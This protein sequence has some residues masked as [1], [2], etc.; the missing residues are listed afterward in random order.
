MGSWKPQSRYPDIGP[1]HVLQL[2]LSAARLHVAARHASRQLGPSAQHKAP[3][4]LPGP[5]GAPVPSSQDTA[6][7]WTRMLENPAVRNPN[8]ALGQLQWILEQGLLDSILPYISS[9]LDLQASPP[10]S[11]RRIVVASSSAS[12]TSE[13]LNQTNQSGPSLIPSGRLQIQ[14]PVSKDSE[15]DEGESK[16]PNDS[17]ATAQSDIQKILQS[18]I[19][20]HPGTPKKFRKGGPNVTLPKGSPDKVEGTANVTVAPSA[21]DDAPIASDAGHDSDVSASTSND[22]DQ[23]PTIVIHVCD[24]AHGLRQD[25][26]CSRD[27]LVRHIGYFADLT[28][29]QRLEDVDISVHCDVAVFEWL[30]RWVKAGQSP[31]HIKPTIEAKNAVSLLISADF[32][33]MLPLVSELLVYLHRHAQDVLLAQANL[34]CLPDQL[35]N[36]LSRQFS[37]WEVEAL[38]DPKDRLQGRLYSRLLQA[39]C[40]VNPEHT[41][42]IFRTAATLYRC[43]DCGALVTQQVDRLVECVPVNTHVTVA[44]AVFYAHTRDL[45]WS[46]T[47]HVKELKSSLKTWRLVYWRLWGQVHFMPCSTCGAVFPAAE[48]RRCRKHKMDPQFN[49][50]SDLSALSARGGDHYPC[51]GA[52]ALRFSP[53]PLRNGCQMCE[54]TVQLSRRPEEVWGALHSIYDDL[55]TYQVL[56][57]LPTAPSSARPQGVVWRGVPLVPVRTDRSF[58]DRSCF[59][60][61]QVPSGMSS[62]KGDTVMVFP[63]NATSVSPGVKQ[64]SKSSAPPAADDQLLGIE[65]GASKGSINCPKGDTIREE[66][67]GDSDE[68]EGGPA[69]LLPPKM[70][71]A[72]QRKAAR[73]KRALNFQVL[74]P[75]NWRWDVSRSARHN[76]DIQRDREAQIMKDLTAWLSLARASDSATVKAPKAGP[77]EGRARGGDKHDGKQRREPPAINPG[78]YYKLEAEFRQKHSAQHTN[79]HGAFRAKVQAISRIK[80]R[81]RNRAAFSANR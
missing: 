44:G 47:E 17:L 40:E 68:N 71:A 18:A 61:R 49:D 73:A 59:S 32:L 27:L 63:R 5:K 39:L 28:R 45:S 8:V 69:K 6:D 65:S 26:S 25:F 79:S 60:S 22:K 43:Q 38:Q 37:H 62:D 16:T 4:G 56:I 66:L 54:H 64:N 35:L 72:L 1:S 58:L 2:L 36:R 77:C 55:L 53:L 29:G 20:S 76:Q 13:S 41:R 51:C 10:E 24:E 23:S 19:R 78:V 7:T 46:L 67:A 30:L 15:K 11:P 14:A 21:A 48:L 52:R 31:D 70:K 34:S 57:C 80:M 50:A 9:S 42:G 3:L 33:K 74:A 81:L 75:P 12:P